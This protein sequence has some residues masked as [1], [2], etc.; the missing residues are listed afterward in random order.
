MR[1]V[2]FEIRAWQADS[3]HVQLLVHRSPAGSIRR[4]ITVPFRLADFRGPAD[5]FEGGVWWSAEHT[6]I[7]QM[8]KMGR[9]LGGVVLPPPIHL[10]LTNSIARLGDDDGLRI[11]LCLDPN[12]AALNWEF[13]RRPESDDASPLEGFLAL[14]PRISIA[15][16]PALGARNTPPSAP[17]QRIVFAGCRWDDDWDRWDVQDEYATVAA[18]VRRGTGMFALE[19]FLSSAGAGIEEALA[20]TATVFHYSGHTG[21]AKGRAYLT[22]HAFSEKPRG[23]PQVVHD[24]LAGEGLYCDPLY[25]SSLGSLLRRAGVQVGVFSACYSTRWAFVEPLIEAGLPVLIGA[26]DVVSNKGSVLFSQKLYGALAVGLSLDEAVSAARVHV[27]NHTGDRCYDWGAFAVYMNT[28]SAVLVA[29]SG[30]SRVVHA[31]RETILQD[32]QQALERAAAVAHPPAEV[33]LAAERSG[34]FVSYAHENRPWL[35]RLQVHL[36]PYVR[37]GSLNLWDDT[38]IKTGARW[39]DEIRK[40][41]GSARV[42]VLLVTPEFLGSDFIAAD[43]LPP[44]LKEA[45]RDGV[46]IVAVACSSSSYQQSPLAEFQWANDPETPLDGLSQ[47]E[48]NRAL[49]SV[50][51]KIF[52]AWSAAP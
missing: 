27:L 44:L 18:E 9:Q 22:K 41:L 47:A 15:R 50:C 35:Q 14:D 49:V 12:L 7:T 17:P 36:R 24:S 2:D 39:R 48:Q 10:L 3:E 19:P 20:P 45:E 46:T 32:R 4:P 28:A 34:V 8:A 42:A 1:F 31:Q 21:A 30:D 33:P 25:V 51:K 40:A 43:E 38:R 11:R 16:E 37:E 29:N 26:P 5:I 52:D 6:V 13:L 23:M